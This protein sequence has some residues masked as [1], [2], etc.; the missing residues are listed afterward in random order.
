MK[1]YID[2]DYK[3]CTRCILDTTSALIKFDSNGVC[4]FCT[5]YDEMAAKSVLRPKKERD[6][7]LEKTLTIIKGEGKGKKYDCILGMSGGLDSSYLTVLAVEFG[8]RPLIVHFD[9]G[10]NSELAVKNIDNIINKLKLDLHTYVIDWEEFKDLQLAYFKS[11]VIDIEVPT[12][13]LIFSVLYKVAIENDIKYILDGSNFRMENGMPLDWA[14][15]HKFDL[16]N[17]RNIHKKY[18]K[19]K[20]RKFPTL[21]KSELLIYNEVYH[22]KTYNLLN[23]VDLNPKQMLDKLC[24]E[25]N[26]KPYLY[27]HYESIFTR[28]YQGYILPKKWNVDKRK[29]HLSAMI[30]SNLLSKKDAL[31]ELERPTYPIEDQKWDKE[32]V[33]KKW[34]ITEKEFEDVMSSKPVSH[35]VF[36]FDKVSILTKIRLKIYLVYLFKIAY[37]LGLK[38]RIQI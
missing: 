2:N 24:N 14:F 21:S 8:L 3:M 22:I 23:L 13:Q 15:E 6:V 32:Y 38:K 25:Y 27:K 10:W 30:R 5:R 9:N 7:Q 29:A 36:G 35:E 34:G 11:G 26:Y 31:K 12:D 20:L 37:P 16:T 19:V 17:L 18:G 1:D 33:I 4:N 28:F